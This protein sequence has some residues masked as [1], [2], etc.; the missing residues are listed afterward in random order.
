MKI[1]S[2][3]VELELNIKPLEIGAT[4]KI[5]ITI[6]PTSKINAYSLFIG[7]AK[8]ALLFELIFFKDKN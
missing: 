5:I 8:S 7:L 4:I 3:N 2:K 1:K 6:I